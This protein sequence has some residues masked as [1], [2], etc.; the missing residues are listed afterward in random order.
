MHSTVRL[1]VATAT[2]VTALL[3]AAAPA[4]ASVAGAPADVEISSTPSRH[5]TVAHC[6]LAVGYTTDPR[7]ITYVVHASASAAG[8]SVAL[9]TSVQ[10]TVYDSDDPSRTYGGASGSMP[11]PRVESVGQATVPAGV[12]PTLCVTAGATFLDGTTKA[13]GRTC[14]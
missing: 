4:T 6:A 1:T 2:A 10:C 9:A 5:T 7:F 12:I 3:V 13:P 8:P 14:P 11:G